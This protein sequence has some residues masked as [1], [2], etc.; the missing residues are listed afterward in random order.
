MTL[1]HFDWQAVSALDTIGSPSVLATSTDL[2]SPAWYYL[3][4]YVD[5]PIN[6]N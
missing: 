1:E 6:Q 2:S 3:S 4:Y 5:T